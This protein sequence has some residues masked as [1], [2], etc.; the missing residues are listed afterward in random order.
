MNTT[1]QSKEGSSQR[2]KCLAPERPSC[3]QVCESTTL[4]TLR[5]KSRNLLS[6]EKITLNDDDKEDKEDTTPLVQ[7]QSKRVCL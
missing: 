3:P 2:V 6:G 5:S 4:A 1:M 7:R